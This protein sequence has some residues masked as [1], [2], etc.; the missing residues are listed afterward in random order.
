MCNSVR[1]KGGGGGWEGG[2]ECTSARGRE[3]NWFEPPVSA[4]IVNEA[5]VIVCNW[6]VCVC[7]TMIEGCCIANSS[8]VWIHSFRREKGPAGFSHR[9]F[10]S[11]VLLITLPHHSPIFFVCFVLLI[12]CYSGLYC[13]F[14]HSACNLWSNFVYACDTSRCLVQTMFCFSQQLF[15]WLLHPN[16]FEE[17][18]SVLCIICIHGLMA[19]WQ[20]GVL[21]AALAAALLFSSVLS[22]SLHSESMRPIKGRDQYQ[23]QLLC[24]ADGSLFASF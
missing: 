17:P 11:L 24:L 1:G 21:K 4:H 6:V 22:F 8:I 9:Y 12:I 14:S 7:A 20:L 15:L 10:R 23:Q 16:P 18:C 19:G 5:G 13:V 2:D 3:R